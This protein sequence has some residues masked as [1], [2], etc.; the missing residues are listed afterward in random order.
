LCSGAQAAPFTNGGFETASV[1]P[2]GSY[3]R[4]TQGSTAITGWTVQSGEIDYI[5]GLWQAADGVRSVDLDGAVNG[6]I[7]QTFDTSA[8]LSYEV[9]FALAGNPESGPPIKT[10]RVSAANQVADFTFNITGRTVGDMGYVDQLFTFTAAS[11]STTLTFQSLT[12]PAGF[13]ATIDNVRLQAITAAAPEPSTLAL[14]TS[15]ALPLA[16]MAGMVIRK[17]HSSRRKA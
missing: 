5:G 6:A 15:L 2:G 9:R 17:R 12:S 16:G 7:S 3:L 14:L 4:F 11:T 10:V 8:G 13:G 1:N